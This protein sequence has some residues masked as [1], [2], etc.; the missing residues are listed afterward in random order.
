MHF[1]RGGAIGEIR[2]NRNRES[3]VIH[4][5]MKNAHKAVANT[6]HPFDVHVQFRFRIDQV[7]FGL[8]RELHVNQ[9]SLSV[10][11]TFKD[12]EGLL[13]DRH[14]SLLFVADRA[15]DEVLLHK[16]SHEHTVLVSRLEEEE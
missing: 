9:V 3:E 10:K 5:I 8:V 15:V 16:R 7:Y 13:G 6:L 12:Y 14:H 11:Q 1:K 4:E 2:E